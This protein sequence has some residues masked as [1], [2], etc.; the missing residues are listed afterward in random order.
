VRDWRLSAN[1]IYQRL[2]PAQSHN[3]DEH[4][5]LDAAAHALAKVCGFETLTVTIGLPHGEAVD[6]R[7]RRQHQFDD[8]VLRI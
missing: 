8:A 6:G 4:T 5:A 3:C 1:F 7:V 2:R